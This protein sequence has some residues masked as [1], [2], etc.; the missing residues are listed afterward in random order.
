MYLQICKYFQLNTNFI[1]FSNSFQW[2]LFENLWYLPISILPNFSLSVVRQILCERKFENSM[3][4]G[5]LRAERRF[6]LFWPLFWIFPPYFTLLKQCNNN[7]LGGQTIFFLFKKRRFDAVLDLGGY[8]EFWAWK[9]SFYWVTIQSLL[10][11]VGLVIYRQNCFTVKTVKTI[12]FTGLPV[13]Y[14]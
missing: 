14:R 9:K 4:F 2:K 13:I 11:G 3:K 6:F 8:L 1:P 12:C 10:Y 5:H 7:P